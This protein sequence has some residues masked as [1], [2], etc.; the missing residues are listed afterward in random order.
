MDTKTIVIA[1]SSVAGLGIAIMLYFNRLNK[2]KTAQRQNLYLEPS[3]YEQEQKFHQEGLTDYT[4]GEP[5]F[6]GK[7]KNR[8]KKS[9]K[10]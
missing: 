6:G 7:R 5:K 9:K 2:I 1:G 8:T 4:D 10:K 3:K